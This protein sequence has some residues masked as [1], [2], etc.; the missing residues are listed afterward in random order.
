M[1]GDEEVRMPFF[2]GVLALSVGIAVAIGIRRVLDRGSR[3]VRAGLATGVFLVLAA[4][5][6]TFIVGR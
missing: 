2:T 3:G 1:E 6:V 5:L 4:A